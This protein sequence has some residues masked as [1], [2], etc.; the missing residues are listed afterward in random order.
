[1]ATNQRPV[2]AFSPVSPVVNLSTANTSNAVVA[3]PADAADFRLL[4]TC[5]IPEGAKCTLV[6]FQFVGTGTPAAGVFNI[7]ATDSI[8][9]N[10]RV[11]RTYSFPV[12]AG[13]ISTTV[14]GLYVEIPFQDLQLQNG[15]KLFVSVTTLA[16]NTTL[17]VRASIGEF[18]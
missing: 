14:A 10:A 5:S 9:N 18:A 13:A 17:N 6:A 1:M 11:I 12:S 3:S 7:W 16:S 2:F 15:Q 4:Y 8:G